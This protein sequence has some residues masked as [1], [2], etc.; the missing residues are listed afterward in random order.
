M[1]DILVLY[2]S[3]RGSVREMA[4]WIARSIEEID[5][6]GARLRAVPRLTRALQD[7][8]VTVHGFDGYP[9][10]GPV[11][12]LRQV[13]DGEKPATNAPIRVSSPT[14]HPYRFTSSRWK[15]ITR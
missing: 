14:L 6:V 2:Y 7:A 1:S 15:I 10:A 13:L 11:P 12:S 4:Q 8:G 9:I 5:D 3:H